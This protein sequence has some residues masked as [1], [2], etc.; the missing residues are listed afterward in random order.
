MNT[1]CL[2]ICSFCLLIPTALV[3]ISYSSLHFHLLCPLTLL[4]WH[5]MAPPLFLVPISCPATPL[6]WWGAPF[7]ATFI[8]LPHSELT[9]QKSSFELS[10][11]QPRTLR[12]LRMQDSSSVPPSS[13]HPVTPMNPCPHTSVYLG[14]HPGEDTYLSLL[15]LAQ[16]SCF[17]TTGCR[18]LFFFFWHTSIPWLL[19]PIDCLLNHP[20]L[21][22]S[23]NQPKTLAA[24]KV[25]GGTAMKLRLPLSK[26]TATLKRKTALPHPVHVPCHLYTTVVVQGPPP[27]LVHFLIPVT[28]AHWNL[29]VPP[30]CTVHTVC[31]ITHLHCG[32]GFLSLPSSHSMP[33]NLTLLMVNDC[34]FSVW[35]LHWADMLVLLFLVSFT[36]PVPLSLHLWSMA[37]SIIHDH[38]LRQVTLLHECV[39]HLFTS[40][41]HYHALS[42][43][44]PFHNGPGLHFHAYINYPVVPVHC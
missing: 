16:H 6:H 35:S 28:P 9:I 40:F 1:N 31:P 14:R 3:I 44:I 4:Q 12:A 17:Y 29:R 32:S 36:S 2:V 22:H 19:F 42:S 8:S 10:T 37:L 38:I 11:N 15:W 30:L 21:P 27:C 25:H 26:Y 23:Q 13:L 5:S 24:L 18:V 43:Y 7:F 33:R 41:P 34:P 20:T 39:W